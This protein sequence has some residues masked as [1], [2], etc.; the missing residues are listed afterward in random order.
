VGLAHD[1]IVLCMYKLIRIH[2]ALDFHW[3][4]LEMEKTA[5]IKHLGASVLLEMFCVVE[6]DCKLVTK[7]F[8]HIEL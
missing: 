4:P 7:A 5:P 6:M 3:K 1:R 8:N 2:V